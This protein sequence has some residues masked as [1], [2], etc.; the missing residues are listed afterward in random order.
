MK[1]K[2]LLYVLMAAAGLLIGVLLYALSSQKAEAPALK[3]VPEFQLPLLSDNTRQLNK[4]TLTDGTPRV[5]NFFASWCAP[6]IVELPQ[7]KALKD[8]G[9]PIVGIAFQD[10]PENIIAFLEKHDN[11]YALAAIDSKGAA[12]IGWGLLGVPETFVTD[13]KGAIIWHFR[14]GLEPKH[15]KEI[16]A[17]LGR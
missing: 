5:I 9:I 16:E 10:T 12:S 1:N 7:L 13:G 3:A 4:E 6:C 17:A 8:K 2:F 11:P 14:G 15:I